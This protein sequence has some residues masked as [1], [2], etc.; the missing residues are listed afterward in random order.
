MRPS[1]PTGG[2]GLVAEGLDMA[3]WPLCIAE[4]MPILSS[5]SVTLARRV[6]SAVVP[7]AARSVTLRGAVKRRR[8]PVGE[9]LQDRRARQRVDAVGK[10][11]A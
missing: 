9:R 8:R 6:A 4:T 10:P 3:P 2:T 5:L 7:A 11:G 1:I